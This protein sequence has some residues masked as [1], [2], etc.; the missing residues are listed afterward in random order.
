MKRNNPCELLGLPV[1]VKSEFVPLVISP[2]TVFGVC[3]F[4]WGVVTVVIV[5]VVVTPFAVV[6]VVWIVVVVVPS[7]VVTVVV[8][9]LGAGTPTR[10]MLFMVSAT[11]NMHALSTASPF[12]VLNRALLPVP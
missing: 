7:V 9:E 1:P 4:P 11:Y 10:I 2:F 12:G 8:V 5:V 6:T 3:V